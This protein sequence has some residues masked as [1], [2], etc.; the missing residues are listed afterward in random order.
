[1][2]DVQKADEGAHP[3]P[4]R[5]LN[6]VDYRCEECGAKELRSVPRPT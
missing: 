1:M 5:I 2:P 6:E 3:D 4:G